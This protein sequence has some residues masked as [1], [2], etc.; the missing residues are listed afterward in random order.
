[1]KIIINFKKLVSAGFGGYLKGSVKKTGKAQV[2]IDIDTLLNFCVDNK[3]VTFKKIF[4]EVVL[5]EIL[6]GIEELFDKSFNHKRINTAL[7]KVIKY[8]KKI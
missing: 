2:I 1:M 3:E 4:S 7:K 5:H 6:H 8:D